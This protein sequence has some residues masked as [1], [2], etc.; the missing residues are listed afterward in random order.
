MG[1]EE[2]DL[3]R[4]DAVAAQQPARD[5]LGVLD[6]ELEHRGPFLFHVV[7]ALVVDV[8]LG[9]HLLQLFLA[10]LH[11]SRKRGIARFVET[12]VRGDNGGQR[13]RVRREFTFAVQSERY[14]ELF[15]ALVPA[16]SRGWAN[17]VC[18]S[19]R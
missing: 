7:Q 16:C 18:A 11:D 6:G 14:A 12:Q 3:R 4:I 10:R 9:L 2:V 5:L 8:P 19:L 13:E 1:H 17:G 15:D